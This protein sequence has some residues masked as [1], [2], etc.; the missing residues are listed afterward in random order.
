MLSDII[1]YDLR[2]LFVGINP[3]PQSY[4][5]GMPYIGRSNHFWPCFHSSGLLDKRVGP[6]QIGDLL[7]IHRIGFTNICARPTVRASELSVREKQRGAVA[8]RCLIEE[9]RLSVVCFLGVEAYTVFAGTTRFRLGL[10][11]EV[12]T[13]WSNALGGACLAYV[14]PSTSARV[15]A[16]QLSDKKEFFRELATYVIAQ[17]QL[18]QN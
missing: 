4:E 14:M 2:L 6:R 11:E 12:I 8:L 9:Y 1:D 13:R 10:Q 5:M 15:V 18:R 16:Y 17:Q 7:N 3:D